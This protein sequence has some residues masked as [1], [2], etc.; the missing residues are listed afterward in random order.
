MKT[1]EYHARVVLSG[2][3]KGGMM[4]SLGRGSGKF[5][6]SFYILVCSLSFFG[7]EVDEARFRLSQVL[8]SERVHQLQAQVN[9]WLWTKSSSS[10]SQKIEHRDGH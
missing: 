9:E 8:Q 6:A 1:T 10:V 5:E 4:I 7:I 2:E 3:V